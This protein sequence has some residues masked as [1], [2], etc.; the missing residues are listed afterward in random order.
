MFSLFPFATASAS[1]FPLLSPRIGSIKQKDPTTPRL[2]S[3]HQPPPVFPAAEPEA[4]AGSAKQ[5]AEDE[6]RRLGGLVLQEAR[7]RAG[8]RQA[9]GP[10]PRGEVLRR[11]AGLN[12]VGLNLRAP[13][14]GEGNQKGTTC[15]LGLVHVLGFL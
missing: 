15:S 3:R 14:L 9:A 6:V 4:P 1:G 7:D 8:L 2:T 12:G 10:H 11:A 5:F 13:V